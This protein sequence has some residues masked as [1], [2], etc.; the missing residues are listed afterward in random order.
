MSNPEPWSEEAR[1]AAEEDGFAQNGSLAASMGFF[2][3]LADRLEALRQHFDAKVTEAQKV[4]D[5]QVERVNAS[6]EASRLA[7]RKAELE[8]E[9]RRV[10]AEHLQNKVV[11]EIIEKV[12]R[13]LAEPIVIKERSRAGSI[14][15]RDWFLAAMVALA[16]FGVGYGLR[17]WQDQDAVRFLR[18]CMKD[19]QAARDGTLYC[20]MGSAAGVKGST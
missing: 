16:V 8:V 14:Q 11:G 20:R 19:A 6:I 4:A 10:D 1:R 13:H 2:G 9:R 18:G 12:D 5:A 17:A 15:K 7:T 3:K